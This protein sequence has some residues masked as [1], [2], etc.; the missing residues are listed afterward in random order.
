MCFTY[1]PIFEVKK[2]LSKQVA[3]VLGTDCGKIL[4]KFKNSMRDP[5]C[6]NFVSQ[7]AFKHSLGLFPNI[8]GN[9]ITLD[10]KFSALL[11]Q[12]VFLVPESLL[13]EGQEWKFNVEHEWPEALDSTYLLYGLNKVPTGPIWVVCSS[14]SHSW[15]PEK[16]ET[17]VKPKSYAHT[18]SRW[19]GG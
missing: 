17:L 19:R 10:L 12:S 15:R 9:C 8:D 18:Q 6:W 16:W 3:K 11:S 1:A 2:I 4:V 13:V 5:L 14:L 7:S